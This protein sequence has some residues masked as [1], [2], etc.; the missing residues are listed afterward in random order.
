MEADTVG[1]RLALE[2]WVVSVVLVVVVVDAR[3]TFPM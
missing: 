2:A 3:S 1:P